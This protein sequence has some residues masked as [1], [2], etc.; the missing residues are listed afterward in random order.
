LGCCLPRLPPLTGGVTLPRMSKRVEEITLRA[1]R[2]PDIVTTIKTVG[3]VHARGPSVDGEATAIKAT[4]ANQGH[5]IKTSH[6]F[7]TNAAYNNHFAR[8]C[9]ILKHVREL[10]KQSQKEKQVREHNRELHGIFLELTDS[11]QDFDNEAP[12]LESHMIALAPT[13]GQILIALVLALLIVRLL[14]LSLGK[15]N[16][17]SV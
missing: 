5:T 3:E 16:F 6:S 10:Y 2:S 4:I 12:N 15:E 13:T 14:T 9:R 8:D 17:S 7:A 11:Y 1:E